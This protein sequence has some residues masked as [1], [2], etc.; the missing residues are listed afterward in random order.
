MLK[1]GSIIGKIELKSTYIVCKSGKNLAK[2][3]KHPKIAP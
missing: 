3:G 2:P 1:N